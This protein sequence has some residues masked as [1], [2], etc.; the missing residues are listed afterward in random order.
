MEMKDIATM[1]FVKLLRETVIMIPI[2]LAISN[3][4]STTADGLQKIIHGYLTHQ[5]IAAM[6][7]VNTIN[8]DNTYSQ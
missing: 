2:V 8:C 1:E 5:M 3:V 7:Q 4:A 6:I